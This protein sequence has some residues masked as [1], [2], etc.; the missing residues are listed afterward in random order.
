MISTNILLL[1]HLVRPG[2][3]LQN[4]GKNDQLGTF[5]ESTAPILEHSPR[6]SSSNSVSKF[7]SACQKQKKKLMIREDVYFPKKNARYVCFQNISFLR[8]QD[9]DK[10]FFKKTK[11]KIPTVSPITLISAGVNIYRRMTVAGI[12]SFASS[13]PPNIISKEI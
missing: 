4:E 1:F 8:K 6:T 10:I 9:K 2:P 11:E 7:S 13:R 12:S 3:L 5:T